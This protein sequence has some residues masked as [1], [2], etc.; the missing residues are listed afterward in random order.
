MKIKQGKIKTFFR[1]VMAILMVLIGVSHFT[2]P[3]KFVRIVPD[4][5]P[6]PLALVYISGFFEIVGGVGLLIP[7]LTRY[8]AWGLIA[9]YVAVFPA[10]VNMVI[11]QLPFGENPVAPI[12]L[13]LRLPLQLVIIAWAYWFTRE[14][15]SPG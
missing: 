8:A 6:A 1:W 15:K 3:D 11:H 10:N 9:L 2:D 5:L 14:E 13:W 4:Y 12:L 7:Q